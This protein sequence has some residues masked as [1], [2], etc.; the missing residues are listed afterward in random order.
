MYTSIRWYLRLLTVL[1]RPEEVDIGV[2]TIKKNMPFVQR[3]IELDY[4]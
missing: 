2:N 1:H 3:T 4:F